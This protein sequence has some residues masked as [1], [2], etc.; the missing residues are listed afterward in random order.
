ME[1]FTMRLHEAKKIEDDVKLSILASEV[2][3]DTLSMVSQ[4]HIWHWQTQKF[5]EHKA[6]GDFYESL[7]GSVDQLAEVFMGAGG[8]LQNIKTNSLEGYKKNRVIDSLNNFR[9][10]LNDTQAVFLEKENSPFHSVGD[11]IL[12][13]VKDID[14]L[15]YLLTLE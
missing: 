8:K 2:I 15:L 14:K 12:D 9:T 10:K 6:L 3:M 5:A 1:Y 11:I 4:T 13:I 7:Q